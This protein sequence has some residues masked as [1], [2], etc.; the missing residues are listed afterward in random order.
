MSTRKNVGQILIDK[1][2]QINPNYAADGFNDMGE[3]LSIIL[4][5]M[6]QGSAGGSDAT[7]AGPKGLTA[8]TVRTVTPFSADSIETYVD[9][10]ALKFI[11]DNEMELINAQL[12]A[13]DIVMQQKYPL[14]SPQ[15]EYL[16]NIN[17]GEIFYINKV[18]DTNIIAQLIINY[19]TAESMV[20]EAVLIMLTPLELNS[21]E[22]DLVIM[23]GYGCIYANG[24]LTSLNNIFR[25]NPAIIQTPSLISDD[26]AI[27]TDDN[28]HLSYEELLLMNDGNESYTQST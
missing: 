15:G 16:D 20:P 17:S 23:A 6:N 9:V 8:E 14:D 12:Q 5:N 7:G 19:D 21:I 13:H 26:L 1:A 27:T 28:V 10:D 4:E 2:K 3:A 24:V 22:N 18:N 11:A 25:T